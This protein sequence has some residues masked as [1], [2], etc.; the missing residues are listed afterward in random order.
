MHTLRNQIYGKFMGTTAT[1][2]ELN[3]STYNVHNLANQL[4]SFFLP[5]LITYN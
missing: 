5:G 3:T 1:E 2:F 4:T